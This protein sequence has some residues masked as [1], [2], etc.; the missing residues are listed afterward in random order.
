MMLKLVS[1][2]QA[3]GTDAIAANYFWGQCQC[4]CCKVLLM[5][6]QGLKAA[7]LVLTS[8]PAF[9]ASIQNDSDGTEQDALKFVSSFEVMMHGPPVLLAIAAVIT[10][11]G[12]F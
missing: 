3:F 9:D 6:V 12:L 11:K 5:W 1:A 8:M 4:K 10:L 2:R 7:G